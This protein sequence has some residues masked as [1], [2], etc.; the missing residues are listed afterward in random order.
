MAKLVAGASYRQSLEL[1]RSSLELSKGECAAALRNLAVLQLRCILNVSPT[2]ACASL[3]GSKSRDFAKTPD[4]TW[5]SKGKGS[6]AS[7]LSYWALQ[8]HLA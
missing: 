2:G 3:A 8:W 7:C 6:M 4:A 1:G 5:S